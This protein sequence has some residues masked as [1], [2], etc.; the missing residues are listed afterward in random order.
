[1]N[2]DLLYQHWPSIA[3]LSV[4][5][6]RNLIFTAAYMKLQGMTNVE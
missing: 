6:I 2:Y 5:A 1:M 3:T 4:F